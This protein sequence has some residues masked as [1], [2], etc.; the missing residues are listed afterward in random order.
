MLCIKAAKAN[1]T[2]VPHS[3]ICNVSKVYNALIECLYLFIMSSAT[4]TGEDAV[5]QTAV[6]VCV[7]SE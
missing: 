6:C 3:T 1:I 7:C 4:R 5:L 2:H